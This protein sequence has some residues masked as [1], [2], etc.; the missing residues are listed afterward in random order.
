MSQAIFLTGFPGFLGSE[1]VVRLLERYPSEV[2]LACLVQSK[3]WPLAEQRVADLEKQH[4]QWAGRIQLFNGDITVA[5]LGLEPKL[6]QRLQAEIVEI[7]HLAAI[8]D[9]GVTRPLGL[10]VN[11]EGT[12]FMLGFAEGSPNLRRFHYISTCYVSGRYK[13]LFRETDLDK[14]QT[15]NNYYE[16]TKYLAEVAVQER[17]AQG[18]PITIYRP[19]IVQGDSRTGAT[20]KYDGL[21]YLL[22][23]IMRQ[24]RW[25]LV[26]VLGNPRHY[27]VNLVPSDFVV[28]AI[29]YL[30][31]LEQS[32]GKVYQLCDPHPLTVEQLLKLVAQ[33]TAHRLIRLPL[34]AALAQTVL[35]KIPGLR[36]FTGIEPEAFNYFTHP[37]VYS[38][39]ET[40]R[41]LAGS[42]ISCPSYA[43]YISL[44]ISFLRE[45]W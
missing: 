14:G 15:F 28:E 6:S 40:M 11:V 31:G 35:K 37:T 24:P 18:L 2:S 17:M 43:D 41:D 25:A 30:S 5:N 8:Y 36:R 27:E 10:R 34:P 33:A 1:L 3:F 9:L 12:R 22:R 29:T 21:Y 26:P 20:Q 38:C 39:E 23:W 7:Y 13:G 42:G 16:E 32:K 19:A 45:H 44:L 4:P